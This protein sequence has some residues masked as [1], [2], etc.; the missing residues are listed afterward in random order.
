MFSFAL[1]KKKVEFG[2]MEFNVGD[3]QVTDLFSSAAESGM[4]KD[5]EDMP[6][7]NRRKE[8]GNADHFDSAVY[9]GK[10]RGS[11]RRRHRGT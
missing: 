5:S 8:E 3:K 6:C 11:H 7:T 10:R 1:S 4:I 2:H 9:A